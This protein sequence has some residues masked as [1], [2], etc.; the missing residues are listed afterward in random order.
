MAMRLSPMRAWMSLAHA[1][2]AVFLVGLTACAGGIPAGGSRGATHSL[3]PAG[4]N[5]APTPNPAT[6]FARLV[7]LTEYPASPIPSLTVHARRA[8]GAGITVSDV[9]YPSPG[10]GTVSAWLVEPAGAGLHPA[11]VYLH[12]SETDRDDLRD[13]AIAVAYGGAITMVLD[14]PFA[15]PGADRHLLLQRYDDVSVEQR[16]NAVAVMDVRRALDILVAR[17]D[18]D[19]G[20]LGFVGHSWGANIGIDVAA[21]DPRLHAALLMVPRPSW[22]GYLRTARVSWVSAARFNT[23]AAAWA[24]YLDGM[25]PFDALPLVPRI[26][27]A[28]IFLQYGSTDGVIPQEIS[29]QLVEALNPGAKV[30]YYTAGHALNADATAD[31]IAWLGG[32]LG[33]GSVPARVIATVGLPDE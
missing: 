11:I 6:L 29:Q 10:G 20:R 13:E 5:P 25:A 8:A 9:S 26:E 12:G 3:S 2:L 1:A 28:N 33:L 15:E 30:S 21:R 32:R 19:P 23:P 17:P 7:A 18:V 27:G 16:V 31:R 4:T 24:R 22:T 14:A